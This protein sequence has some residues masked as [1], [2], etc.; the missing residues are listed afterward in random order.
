[1]LCWCIGWCLVVGFV[2]AINSVVL[3]DSLRRLVV[4]VCSGLIV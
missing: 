2:G 4:F 3:G 1:M